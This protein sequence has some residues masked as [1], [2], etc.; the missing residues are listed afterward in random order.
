MGVFKEI[1]TKKQRREELDNQLS[2][3]PYYK[4]ID[5]PKPIFVMVQEVLGY[6]VSW[7][8]QYTESSQ[9]ILEFCNTHQ[10]L[11]S[12]EEI[13]EAMLLFEE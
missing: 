12:D 3:H 1:V 4:R 13:I 11:E 5:I 6:T 7:K 9:D 10:H 8:N 2:V